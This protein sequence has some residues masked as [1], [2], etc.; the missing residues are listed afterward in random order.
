MKASTRSPAHDQLRSGTHHL[1]KLVD[2][3]FDLNTLSSAA[4]Y[5]AFLLANWPFASIEAALGSA[6][7]HQALPDWNKRRRS[8]ALADDLGQFGISPPS[9]RP[10]AI[11]ADL[12]SLLGWSC[13]LEGSR[14]GVAMI[15]RAIDRPGQQV[16]PGTQFLRH[17]DGEQL[18]QSYK[19]A[20]SEIDGDPSAIANACADA[21]L[22]FAAFCRWEFG[23]WNTE[24]N[25]TFS[26]KMQIK[27]PGDG[28]S[29]WMNSRQYQ[30]KPPRAL[31]CSSIEGC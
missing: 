30:A 1:H 20:L 11:A 4:A 23:E 21:N 15:L 7:V 29:I 24:A 22:V 8:K 28:Q 2:S 10:L 13:V 17:G 3:R 9:V 25:V 16:G 18:W 19:E 26:F 6:R 5:S 14:L 27:P 31:Y 12:G